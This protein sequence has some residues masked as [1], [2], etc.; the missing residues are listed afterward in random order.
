MD[1]LIVVS[2]QG[3]CLFLSRVGQARNGIRYV[4]YKLSSNVILEISMLI[5]ETIFL[6]NAYAS[7]LVQLSSFVHH[8]LS[9]S[10]S[11]FSILFAFVFLISSSRPYRSPKRKGSIISLL[12]SFFISLSIFLSRK[13]F[14]LLYI[15]TYIYTYQSEE[16]RT[17]THRSY[18]FFFT[19]W[20]NLAPPL[21]LSWLFY[22]LLHM[23]MYK[24]RVCIY[25]YIYTHK[26][27]SSVV[28]IQE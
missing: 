3:D 23:H 10:G 6:D 20:P 17:L 21:L 1:D 12:L 2:H 14:L 16:V 22:S 28:Y 7:I 8:F 4:Y 27:E 15:H 18:F 11:L 24:N 5:L 25:I 26:K 9:F 13:Y 19:R